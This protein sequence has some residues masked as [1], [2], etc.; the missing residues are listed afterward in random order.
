MAS[1][2]PVDVE[3]AELRTEPQA[4]KHGEWEWRRA[5]EIIERS[6]N[7]VNYSID[8]QLRWER[9]GRY[10]LRLRLIP[11][12]CS[13]AYER[14]IALSCVAHICLAFFEAPSLPGGLSIS[15]VV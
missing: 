9:N 2:T 14:A 15:S 12:F 11:W 3:A 4:E 5:V 6:R 7:G 1:L 10:Q 13:R 8:D